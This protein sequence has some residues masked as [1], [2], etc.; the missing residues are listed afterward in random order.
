MC[1]L[2]SLTSNQDS[3]RRLFK[4]KR[5]RAG[6]T[7]PL[8]AIFPDYLAPVVRTDPDGER[9]IEMMRWGFPPPP[10]LGNY[11]VTN[12]RNLASPY[13]RGWLKKEWR[14]LVPATSFSEYTDSRPKII[15]WFALGEERPLFAFAGIWRPWTG[16]RGTKANPVTGEHLLFSFLTTEP[17]ELVRPIHA[18]A[19]PVILTG[20]ECD[21]WLEGDT[22][23]I[24]ALQRPL[25]AERLRIVATGE[26][27]D[28]PK[29]A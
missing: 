7:P 10:N 5:D 11:P 17:N 23:E 12:V 20:D 22:A 16:T 4:A 19:M 14:C 25:P 13:W 27:Q 3:I 21:Q 8:P 29:A 26:K 9:A 6:N 1:N 15:H 2:Y 18:K 28:P 24:L